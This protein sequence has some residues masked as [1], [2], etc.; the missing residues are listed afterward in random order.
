MTLRFFNLVIFS[1][2]LLL[3]S[4]CKKESSVSSK[5]DTVSKTTPV[6]ITEIDRPIYVKATKGD[7]G[8]QIVVKWAPMP[9]AKKYQL[10]KFNEADQQYKLL[11]ETP[12]T[13]YTDIL[14]KPLVKNYYKVKIYNSSTEYSQ[15]SDVDY[16]YTSG[17]TYS[18]FG[19]FGS[20]GTG[21]GQFQFPSNVEADAGG[22]LYVSDEFGGIQK[23]DAGGKFIEYFY[24]PSGAGTRALVFL[25]NGNFVATHIADYGNNVSIF[26]A[27]KQEISSFAP[28]GMGNG[29]GQFGNT[30]QICN[31]KDDNIYIVDQINKRVQKFDKNGKFLLKFNITTIGASNAGWGVCYLND[32]I[33]VSNTAGNDITV[34]DKNGIYVRSFNIGAPSYSIKTDGENLIIGSVGYIIKTDDK[35]QVVEKIGQGQFVS[36]VAGV[37]I[38]KSQDIIATDTYGRKVITFKKL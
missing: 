25:Y 4:A 20:E 7:F 38:N 31:D 22:N 32:N 36:I 17:Q 3:F 13:T 27:Q 16:G 24:K 8:S 28:L 12:D 37:A 26:S 5:A 15:F 33:F 19:V 35:G 34:Y 10:Y 11:K 30:R 6:K 14:G 23:F 2:V 9:L 18:K 1:A 29:D 21:I